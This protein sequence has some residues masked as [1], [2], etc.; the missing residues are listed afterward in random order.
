MIIVFLS[1]IHAN[2]G[3]LFYDI[4]VVMNEKTVFLL[5]IA[6]IVIF[7]VECLCFDLYYRIFCDMLVI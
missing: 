7:L 4:C 1:Y 2:V 6:S 3:F 5:K